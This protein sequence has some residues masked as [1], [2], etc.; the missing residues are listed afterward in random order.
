[1]CGRCSSELLRLACKRD[2]AAGATQEC[3]QRA[4][5]LSIPTNFNVLNGEENKSGRTFKMSIAW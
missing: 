1:M 4:A 3:I 5:L 2:I